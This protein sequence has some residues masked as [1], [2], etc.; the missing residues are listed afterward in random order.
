MMMSE[1]K[2]RVAR[3]LCVD[4]HGGNL[5]PDAILTCGPASEV[6]QPAWKLFEKR[7]HAAITAMRELTEEMLNAVSWTE[8][9]GDGGWTERAP[10]SEEYEAAINAALE[11]NKHTENATSTA[12]KNPSLPPEVDDVTRATYQRM[13]SEMSKRG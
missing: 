1:M 11:E 3:A 9:V 13:I 4:A 8:G 12:V 5:S 2:E 10:F 7:A 6:G